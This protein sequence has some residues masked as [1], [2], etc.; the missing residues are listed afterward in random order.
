M[1]NSDIYELSD[2]LREFKQ[3]FKQKRGEDISINPAGV[4]MLIDELTQITMMARRLENEVSRH[5][6]NEG[7]RHDAVTAAGVAEAVLA[8]IRKPD[9]KVA[10]FPARRPAFTDGHGGA[11]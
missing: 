7:A 2:K 3:R 4:E 10:L 6:W 11:A 1:S 5:R 9:G 8:E